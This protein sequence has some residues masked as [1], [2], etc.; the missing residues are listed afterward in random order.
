MFVNHFPNNSPQ[1]NECAYATVHRNCGK[2]L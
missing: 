2:H 1:G